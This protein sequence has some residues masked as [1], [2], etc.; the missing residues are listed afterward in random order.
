MVRRLE[1]LA[2]GVAKHARCVAA[3]A[4]VPGLPLQS[5]PAE[6]ASMLTQGY[7]PYVIVSRQFV[8]WYDERFRGYGYDKI[9]QLTH[10]ASG[11][12]LRVPSN[13]HAAAWHMPSR[14]VPASVG[15]Q[16]TAGWLGGWMDGVGCWREGKGREGAGVKGGGLGGMSLSTLL[17]AALPCLQIPLQGLRLLT[18][19]SALCAM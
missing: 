1:P 17:P 14:A 4:T 15:A 10:L 6:Q 2:G 3:A 8:P 5:V 18:D 16:A 13:N 7:E 12:E 9:Q 19:G 11:E